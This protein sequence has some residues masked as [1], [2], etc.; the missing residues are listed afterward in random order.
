MVFFITETCLQSPCLFMAS[1]GGPLTICI[2]FYENKTTHLLSHVLSLGNCGT[3]L[4]ALLWFVR[5]RRDDSRRPVV[6]IRKSPMNECTYLQTLLTAALQQTTSVYTFQGDEFVGT[7]AIQQKLQ[8]LPFGTVKHDLS[9]ARLDVQ[10]TKSQ[11]LYLLV[12]GV[13]S[14]LSPV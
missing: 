2:T 10:V 12:T 6:A 5:F 11:G 7:Q 1:F 4:A 8:S 9:T 13:L 14:V 3:V